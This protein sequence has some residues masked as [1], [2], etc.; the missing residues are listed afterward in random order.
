MSQK[1]TDTLRIL[2][3]LGIFLM[4]G[5]CVFALKN[6]ENEKSIFELQQEYAEQIQ[7]DLNG[8]FEPIVGTGNIKTATQVRLQQIDQTVVSKELISA[9]KQNITT[10]RYQ[11]P[12]LKSQHISVLLNST[13]RILEND[14]WALAESALGIDFSKGDTLS[15]KMIPFVHIPFWS[16]GLARLTLIRIA[17]ILVLTTFLLMIILFYLYK[18]AKITPY[19]QSIH[20]NESLWK[21]AIQISPTRLSN[22]L[23]SLSPEVSAFILYRLPS[24]LSGQITNLLPTDYVCQVMIH[25]NHLEN[26]SNQ[27][28][29]NLL[30]QSEASL[31]RLLR[32]KYVADSPEK[33]SEILANSHQKEAIISKMNQQDSKAVQNIKL[34]S[35]SLDDLAKWSN[36][37]FQILMRYLDK[38]TAILALQTAPLKLHQRFEQ[39][40]PSDVWLEIS[41]RCRQ[42]NGTLTE[43]KQA[44]QKMLDVAKNLIINQI[45]KI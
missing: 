19:N 14:A 8:L 43:S 40:L 38:E 24:E 26:L 17:G 35:L 23:N 3:L 30:F 28:Y 32:K 22:T 2:L 11:G 16:F 18:K 7:K 10:T 36:N 25:M 15:I 45:I 44:Q 27:A 1:A 33:I 21:K 13:N 9:H 20:P 34:S 31:T 41:D 39:N 42:M 12:A 6:S 29:Q 37:N 5:W 4:I